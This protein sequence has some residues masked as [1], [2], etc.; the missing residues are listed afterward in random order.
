M[1]KHIFIL[2]FLCFNLTFAN[3]FFITNN[4]VNLKDFEEKENFLIID[5]IKKPFYLLIKDSKKNAMVYEKFKTFSFW[6]GKRKQ[7]YNDIHGTYISF[8]NNVN[9]NYFAKNYLK[10]YF[11]NDI[12]LIKYLKQN[13][14]YADFDL[15]N[16]FN[17][18][19]NAYILNLNDIFV[20]TPII[21]DYKIEMYQKN[22]NKFEMVYEQNFKLKMDW[23]EDFVNISAKKY[24]LLYSIAVVILM[25]Y[26]GIII[27]KFK[28]N[29]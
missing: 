10:N 14:N 2:F 15:K 19:Q 9:N 18:N 20:K 4:V 7:N 8:N 5:D 3:K 11:N 27:G 17:K 13:Y 12:E 6:V 21:G 26:A 24:N 1:I 29:K 28:D 22:N 25:L 23:K 16:Y